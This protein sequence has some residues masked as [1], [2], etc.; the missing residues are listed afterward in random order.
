MILWIDAQLSPTLAQWIADASG[1]EAVALATLG[2]RDAGDFEIFEA[3]RKANAL[4]MTKDS[5]FLNLLDQH[6]PPPQV[7]WITCGNSSNNAMQ[8]ILQRELRRALELLGEGERMVE[9]R[10]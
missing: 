6:G 5:D 2:L 7:L 1:V 3:A 8:V 4:V 10:R 9:I